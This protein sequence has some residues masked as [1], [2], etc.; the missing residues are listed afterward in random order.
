MASRYKKCNK[1]AK[2]AMNGS[3]GFGLEGFGLGL[4]FVFS[5]LVCPR[6][7]RRAGDEWIVPGR[8][9]PL[10]THCRARLSDRDGVRVDESTELRHF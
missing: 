5:S 4:G 6:K 1:K 3:Y 7:H 2:L 8:R 10:A 9:I